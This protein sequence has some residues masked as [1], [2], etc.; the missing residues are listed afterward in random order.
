MTPERLEQIQE[1]YH[2]ARDREPKLRQEFLSVACAGDEELRREVESLLATDPGP[3][4]FLE[5]PVIGAADPLLGQS[6]GSGQS[7][8]IR[9]ME[10]EHWRQIKELFEAA[11]AQP[12]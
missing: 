5:Q 1:L 9:Q 12:P 10:A 11:R 7:A 2:A 8:I 6:V 3:G 4:C